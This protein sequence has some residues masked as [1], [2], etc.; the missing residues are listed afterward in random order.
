LYA[1]NFNF[2]CSDARE[3]TITNI[4]IN[5]FDK[6]Y[7]SGTLKEGQHVIAFYNPS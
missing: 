7:N 5:G 6:E 4:T 3:L 1:F 2:N